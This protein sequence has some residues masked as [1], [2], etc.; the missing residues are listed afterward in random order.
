MRNSLTSINCL[1]RFYHDASHI[2]GGAGLSKSRGQFRGPLLIAS[3]QQSAGV[4]HIASPQQ[5]LGVALATVIS[6]IVPSVVLRRTPP[7][8]HLRDRAGGLLG[9]V[10]RPR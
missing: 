1:V 4:A 5:F 10:C 7:H 6:L 8:G 9:D 2:L 3:P